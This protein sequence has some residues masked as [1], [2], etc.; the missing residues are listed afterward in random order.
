MPEELRE[1][2]R[3]VVV[4]FRSMMF[5]RLKIVTCDPSPENTWP[6]ST[7]MKPPPMMPSR[8]GNSAS[9]MI[10]SDVWNPVSINPAIGGTSGGYRRRAGCS[11]GDAAAFDVEGVRIDEVGRSPRSA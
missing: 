11:G 3:D 6:I 4:E 9:R 8:F 2:V 5:D 10:E 1:T 7:A